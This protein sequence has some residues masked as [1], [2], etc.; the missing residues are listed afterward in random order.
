MKN[1][2]NRIANYF[3]GLVVPP[4]GGVIDVEELLRKFHAEGEE[5]WG[6]D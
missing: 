1:L 4:N 2:F 3:T 5:E 6:G